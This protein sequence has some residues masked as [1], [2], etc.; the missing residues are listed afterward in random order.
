MLIRESCLY[1]SEKWVSRSE[2]LE[3]SGKGFCVTIFVF[4]TTLARAGR[5]L[6]NLFSAA[7]QSREIA[8]DRSI[9]S[10][11]FLDKLDIPFNP[12][13]ALTPSPTL[14]WGRIMD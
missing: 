9:A 12:M 5:I 6:G 13:P 4:L 1:R 10:E 8:D 7:E 14:I 2:M 11:F 3:E